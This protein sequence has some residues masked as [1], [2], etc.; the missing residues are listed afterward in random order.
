MKTRLLRVLEVKK[1]GSLNCHKHYQIRMV[2]LAQ[3]LYFRY[4][5][6]SFC[7]SHSLDSNFLIVPKYIDSR[8]RKYL[9]IY[10]KG[11]GILGKV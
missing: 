7:S 6:L 10:L 2:N 5:L 11:R 4:E 1:S 9:Q 3:N 8:V